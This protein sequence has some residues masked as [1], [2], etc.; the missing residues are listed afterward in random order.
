[1][2]CQVARSM[3]RS[4]RRLARGVL[5]AG[6]VAWRR[7]CVFASGAAWRVSCVAVWRRLVCA[8]SACSSQVLASGYAPGLEVFGYVSGPSTGRRERDKPRGAIRCTV[9]G[10][11]SRHSVGSGWGRGARRVGTAASHLRALAGVA[12]LDVLSSS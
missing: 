8:G 3:K 5:S 7:W 11:T 6:C 9:S 1:M 2:C 12:R 10:N 4:L